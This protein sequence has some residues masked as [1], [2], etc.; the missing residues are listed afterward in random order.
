MCIWLMC[1][2]TRRYNNGITI[3]QYKTPFTWNI[4]HMNCI[5]KTFLWTFA[6]A[7]D[8]GAVSIRKTVSLGMVIPMLKIRRPKDC[9]IFNMGIPIPGKTVFYIE[10]RPRPSFYCIE[11]PNT[12]MQFIPKFHMCTQMLNLAI[13]LLCK[14]LVLSNY[15]FFIIHQWLGARLQ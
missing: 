4:I 9:L 12:D 8:Q 13:I 15:W 6:V 1:T 2:Y 11:W 14:G 5:V 10:T 7:Q 3:L